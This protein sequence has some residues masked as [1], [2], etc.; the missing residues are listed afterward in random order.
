[1]SDSFLVNYTKLS[2]NYSTGRYD[3]TK[4]AVHYVAGPC[5]VYTIGDIFAPSARKASS[6][7]AVDLE[8]RIGMYVHE[9]DR[10]WCTSSAWADNRA[11]T[12]EVANYADGSISKAAWDRLI[13]LMSD[14]CM[15]NDIKQFRYTGTRDGELL[16]HRW[17][18]DTDCPGD[19]LYA[20]FPELADE[21]N[22]R[23]G[24][25]RPC[26]LVVDG[27]WGTRTT[28]R[29]QA[30]LK[31][32]VVDGEIWH[33]WPENRQAAYDSGWKFD[34]T[35]KGSAT[36]AEMQRRL[37]CDDDGIIGE[38]TIRRLQGRMGTPVDGRLDAGSPCI[39][40]MQ[41]RLNLWEF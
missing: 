11:V 36:I 3:I 10:S 4:I 15:R 34:Y 27:Y 41:R 25:G 30:V 35:G 20:R 39:K 18:A 29:L 12:I 37:G 21:V 16:A 1:M 7:Y 26:N 40:E 38:Q 17:F 31:M 9:R 2:P 33:Q 28:A 23:I 6:N 19:W 5:D 32:P 22:R 8:G 24:G 14:I 13:D